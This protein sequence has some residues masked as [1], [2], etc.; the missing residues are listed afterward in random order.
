MGAASVALSL[1]PP[2]LCGIEVV[3]ETRVMILVIVR[4]RRMEWQKSRG[5]MKSDHKPLQHRIC[6]RDGIAGFGSQAAQWMAP[7]YD[8]LQG[9][10]PA[11]A[12]W[13]EPN[14]GIP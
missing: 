14:G 2:I 6:K 12:L 5:Q 4:R 1:A 7:G 11:G 9:S 3:L 10:R 13:L 8:I